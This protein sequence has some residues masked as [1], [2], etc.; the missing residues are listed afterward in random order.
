MIE[1]VR[2]KLFQGSLDE[3]RGILEGAAAEEMGLRAVVTVAREVKNPVPSGSPFVH[4]RLPVD[5]YSFTPKIFFDLASGMGIYPLLVHCSAGVARSRV[6]AA[7]I[8]HRAFGVPLEE[9]IMIADP[10][11]ANLVYHAMIAWTKTLSG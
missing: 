3:A 2:G 10:P 6:F 8:A 5:E 11:K 7:A 1:I 4:L 9:A